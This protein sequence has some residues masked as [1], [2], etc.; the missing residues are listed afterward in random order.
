M[1]G[2][3]I[4]LADKDWKKWQKLTENENRPF[5]PKLVE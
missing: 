3:Y 5:V 2:E 4:D 1:I